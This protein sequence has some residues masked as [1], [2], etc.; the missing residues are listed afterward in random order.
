[1]VAVLELGAS[2][3]HDGSFRWAARTLFETCKRRSDTLSVGEA[4]YLCDA[5]RW[6][7]DSLMPTAPTGGSEEVLDDVI[8]KKVVFR[9]GWDKASTYM[10]L[11]Y[12]DEGDGGWLGRHY[13]RSTISVVMPVVNRLLKRIRSAHSD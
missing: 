7:D 3:F 9:N 6:V 5:H 4:Y 8:G 13:L 12:R 2:V 1:M 10:M 11:N